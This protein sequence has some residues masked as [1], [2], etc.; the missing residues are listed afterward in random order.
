MAWQGI[1][2]PLQG[3]LG[4]LIEKIPHLDIT[5]NSGWG[6]DTIVASAI[7]AFIAAAIPALI[8][9]WSIRNN[10]RTLQKDR[11]AQFRDF[12]RSRDTQIRIA[13]ESRKAQIIA[14]NRLVWIKDLREASAE[15]VSSAYDNLTLSQR[16]V[17]LFRAIETTSVSKSD[18]DELNASL[19]SV[20]K[21]THSSFVKLV[22]H[23]TRI[24]MMLNPERP[25]HL[26][27][28]SA[29]NNI[30]LHS[31]NMIKTKSDMDG[32]AANTYLNEFVRDMQRLLKEEWE[33][34][35]NNI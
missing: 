11:S 7:G 4:L 5:T 16:V 25:E 17:M 3:N 8:A 19:G 22:L 12:E 23:A 20:K 21:E 27:V 2:F 32:D 6:W 13:D 10:N 34:A 9:W 18:K 26:K 29:M 1:P 30:K 35:K 24:Q 15:F 31:E 14:S 28:I 33:K